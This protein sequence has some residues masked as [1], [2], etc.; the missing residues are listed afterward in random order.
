M[1]ITVK[2]KDPE[3][4]KGLIG[5]IPMAHSIFKKLCELYPDIKLPRSLTL[6]SLRSQKNGTQCLTL[7]NAGKT[8]KGKWYIGLRKTVISSDFITLDLL[9]H[10]IAHIGEALMRKKW[11]HSKLWRDI[12]Q[13]LKNEKGV[14]LAD[15]FISTIVWFWVI[16]GI[17]KAFKY[18]IR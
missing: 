14:S 16:V 5:R 13:N 9:C 6:R 15:L 4:T 17:W 7:A 1:K 12:Y 18:L 3:I 10:E 8:E 11:G 2:T